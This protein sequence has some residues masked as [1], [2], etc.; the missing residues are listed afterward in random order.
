MATKYEEYPVANYDTG[1]DQWGSTT[2]WFAQTFTPSTTH[3]I[4]S[5]K[6]Y[7]RKVGSPGTLEVSI[8][9]TDSSSKPTGV[10]LTIGQLAADSISTSYALHEITFVLPYQLTADT[11]Y[12]IVVR[13]LVTS[14]ASNHIEWGYDGSSASYTGGGECVSTDSGATWG[15]EETS[16]DYIFEEWG[17]LTG[18]DAGAYGVVE[19][20][21]YYI[22]AYGSHRYIEGQLAG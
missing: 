9:A 20:Y 7:T 6:L 15:A 17:K 14:N 18:E 22:D 11:K 5:V 2:T 1:A 16:I 21:W 10:D 12:A 4:T 13:T 19:K 3:F 8:K